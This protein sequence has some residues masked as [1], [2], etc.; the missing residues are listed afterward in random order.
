MK[1]IHLDSLADYPT[2]HVI[3]RLVALTLSAQYNQ[4]D[5][6]NVLVHQ[7]ISKALTRLEVALSHAILVNQTHVVPVL[8]VI[9]IEHHPAIVQKM[10]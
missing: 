4:M 7:V 8:D 3:L 5:L 9:Q 2:I 10:R 6:L 1:E